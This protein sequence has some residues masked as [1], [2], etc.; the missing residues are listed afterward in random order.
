MS[1]MKKIENI[2][3]AI[4]DGIHDAGWAN[5][6]LKELLAEEASLERNSVPASGPPKIDIDT[7]SK[8]LKDMQRVLKSGQPENL[9]KLVRLCVHKIRMAPEKREVTIT[10]RIPE[11]FV[12]NLVAGAGFAP[13]HEKLLEWSVER[14]PLP[15]KGRRN[16]LSPPPQ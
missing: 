2:R 6:R 11:P 16:D 3:S 8:H 13:I 14:W 5:S 15:T 1:S 12:N 10:Y 9:K 4:E 7:V